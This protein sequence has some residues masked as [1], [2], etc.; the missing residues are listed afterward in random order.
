MKKEKGFQLLKDSIKGYAPI[1]SVTSLVGHDQKDLFGATTTLIFLFSLSNFSSTEVMWSSQSSLPFSNGFV[2]FP[3]VLIKKDQ[4][5]PN[6][7]GAVKKQK[8]L[9]SSQSELILKFKGRKDVW[10]GS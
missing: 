8:C 9:V 2:M 7:T 3:I 1:K 4:L 6:E 5:W 10:N